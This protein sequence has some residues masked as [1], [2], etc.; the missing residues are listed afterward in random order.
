MVD[1][2]VFLKSK[3]SSDKLIEFKFINLSDE[4]FNV[5][6]YALS[7]L[8]N[9]SD[10]LKVPHLKQNEICKTIDDGPAAVLIPKI[11]GVIKILRFRK[12]PIDSSVF[13]DQCDMY[14]IHIP[15]CA[16]MSIG[17]TLFN[18]GH[19]NGKFFPSRIRHKLRTLVRNPY[20]RMVSAYH[21]MIR[22]GFD[23][24]H[25]H[26]LWIR[27]NF[28]NFEDWILNGLQPEYCHHSYKSFVSSMEP[29]YLQTDFLLDDN[30]EFIL[31]RRHIGRY[32]SLTDDASRIFNIKELPHF[33]QSDHEPWTSYYTNP[34]VQN[35]VYEIYKLD[36]ELLGYSYRLPTIGVPFK[37]RLKQKI[38]RSLK[39]IAALKC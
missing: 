17:Q 37:H 34:K 29:L 15:K 20:D 22:G 4:H 36:F 39:S 2:E 35:R 9:L 14:F 12:I 32:E 10:V 5:Y 38:K 28:K 6:E 23:G 27:D 13:W 3:T 33:N 25:K 30:G 31:D 8:D 19:I 11:D 21:F 24:K 7:K 26:Y 18:F 16:G 1:C